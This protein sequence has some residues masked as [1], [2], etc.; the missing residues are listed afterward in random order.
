MESL[1]SLV[2][3]GWTDHRQEGLTQDPDIMITK[4]LTVPSTRAGGGSEIRIFNVAYK[5]N[6]DDLENGMRTSGF[7]QGGR[8][9]P[10]TCGWGW[11]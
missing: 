7:Q 1:F 11:V 9:S 4:L 3:A 8:D 6:R 2:R 5:A 10:I